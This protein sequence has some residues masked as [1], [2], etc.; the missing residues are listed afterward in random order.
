MEHLYLNTYDSFP[1][2]ERIMKMMRSAKRYIK[3]GNFMF[4]EPVM[5]QEILNALNR[6]VVVFIISNLGEDE[7]RLMGYNRFSKKEYDPHLPNLNDFA[8]RG[9]HVRCMGE[10][11]AK[12]LV[13][14]GEQGMIMSSNYT[15]DSLH[16]NSECGVDLDADNI[17]CLERIFDT[18]FVHADDKIEGRDKFGYKFK[19][20]ESLVNSNVFDEVLKCEIRMTLAAKKLK[21]GKIQDTNFCDCQITG[22]YDAI[23]STIEKAKKYVVLMAYSFRALYK[24]PKI[25]NA[26]IDAAE[27]G[28]SVIL[29]YNSD[30]HGSQAEI[31]KLRAVSSTINALGVPKNH[32]KILLTDKEAFLFTANIDGE[33]GLLSGFELGV[34]LDDTLWDEA[35]EVINKIGRINQ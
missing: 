29:I 13:V 34:F 18:L 14:D 17:F 10:L 30:N 6:G 12:F 22:I 23:N 2:T 21:D 8:E 7:E 24:L 35:R 26:L 5:K 9:A 11:H 32:A 16:G 19:K 20:V 1:L 3:T 28:V 25:R 31:E 27:R 4:R 33:A 15:K